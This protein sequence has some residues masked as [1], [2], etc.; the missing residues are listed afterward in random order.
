MHARRRGQLRDRRADRERMS[1]SIDEAIAAIAAE[2][3]KRF[4]Q[5]AVLRV[6]TASRIRDVV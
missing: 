4:G 5:D 3:K 1:N 2:Y 6:I